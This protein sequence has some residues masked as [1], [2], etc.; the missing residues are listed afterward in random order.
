M[1]EL[2][3]PISSLSGLLAGTH[4][5]DKNKE[6]I[7]KLFHDTRRLKDENSP[8]KDLWFI[9]LKGKK[10][11]GHKFVEE[12]RQQGSYRFIYEKARIKGSVPRL[13]VNDTN[14]FLN[15][16]AS[17]WRSQQDPLVVAITG[18]NGKTSTKELLAF[19]LSNIF[20]PR[21]VLKSKAS[22]NNYF[23]VSFTM[24]EI[25]QHTKYVILELGSN[26]PGEIRLLSRMSKPDHGFITSIELSHIGHFHSKENIAREKSD[27]LMG[28]SAGSDLFFPADMDFTNYIQKKARHKGIIP[29]MVSLEKLGI[30]ISKSDLKGTSFSYKGKYFTLPLLGEHQVR[31]LGL[32]IALL[33]KLKEGNALSSSEIS[34]ALVE[35]QNFQGLD[36]RAK[37]LSYGSFQVCNDSYNANPSSFRSSIEILTRNF[38]AKNLFGAFG[39]MAELGS[40]ELQEHR[41]LARLAA[42]YFKAVAFFGP[43][44][45]VNTA[46]QDTWIKARR[47]HRALFV[48]GIQ[49]KNIQEGASFLHRFLTPEGC[50]L[51]KGSRSVRVER[52]LSYLK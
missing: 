31:N 32:I 10:H 12:L 43:E 8:D 49:E 20:D 28:M 36:D 37:M 39:Y 5:V 7:Q 47:E 48:S 35:L 52:I 15:E 45:K 30:Q 51:V 9:C 13:Q 34:R 26:H 19:I 44:K 2:N 46:F 18:S 33:G 11:D 22:Y 17:L 41:E 14:L 24:L 38:P 29:N 50:L 21:H 25:R 4:Q 27:I 1:Y 23:G 6:T 40:F 16:L 42:K 3:I